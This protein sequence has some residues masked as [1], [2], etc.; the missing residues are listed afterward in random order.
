MM[1]KNIFIKNNLKFDFRVGAGA[2]IYLWLNVNLLPG[3]ICILH[4]P[5][6]YYRIHS[7]QDS[8]LNLISLNIQLY[9]AIFYFSY[10]NRIELWNIIFII[11]LLRYFLLGLE[12][13][14]I[15]Y[16]YYHHKLKAYMKCKK[17]N[18]K[19][20]LSLIVIY[21]FYAFP[22]T[23]INLKKINQLIFRS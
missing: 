6:Y 20:P 11:R 19:W 23:I 4:E 21:F 17:I 18:Y 8:S 1:R 22:N 7:M 14:V 9:D 12:K 15:T 5:L 2:D 10:K 3:Q 13:K 16:E